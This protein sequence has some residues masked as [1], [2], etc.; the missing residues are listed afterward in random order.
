[1]VVSLART[2]SLTEKSG[3]VL[4]SACLFFDLKVEVDVEVDVDVVD[5]AD[6]EGEDGDGNGGVMWAC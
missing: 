3:L 6:K 4:A 5:A 2:L 1:M